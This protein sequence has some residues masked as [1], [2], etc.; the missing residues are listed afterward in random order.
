MTNQLP[1]L[2]VILP[3]F[4]AIFVSILG[5][6][7][8]KASLPLTIAALAGSFYCAIETLKAVAGTAEKLSYRLGG[9]MPPFGIEY[10]IDTLNAMMLVIITAVSLLTAIYSKRGIEKE[11]PDQISSFYTLFLLLVS[12]LLGISITGDVFNLYVLLEI[13][14]LSSYALLAFGKGRAYMSTFQY[15]IM[16]TI[17]ACFYL[18][19]VGY[20][21]LKT[22][23]LNMMHL[24]TILPSLLASKAILVAFIFIMLG[25]WIK[26]ALFPLH[27]WLPNAYSHAPTA[28]SCLIAPL[29]TKVSV[30]VMIRLMFTVF[31]AE[32]VFQTVPWSGV[33]IHIA[34]IAIIA[35]SLFALLQ[36]DL[37]KMLAYIVVAEVGYMVGGAWSNSAFGLAG[38]I[39]HILAD[40]MMTLCLFMAVGC[41]IY[42]TGSSSFDSMK[43]IFKKMPVTMVAFVIGAFSMIGIPPTCGF[44]SKWYLI[45]GALESGNWLFMIALLVSSLINVVL[46][47]RLFEIGFFG[48]VESGEADHRTYKRDEA[49]NSML[50]PLLIA[51]ASCIA[52][53]LYTKEII[54]SVIQ[55]AI[56]GSLL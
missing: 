23:T 18:I 53:G 34:T 21:L 51:S 55:F 4:A 9:W 2:I 35:G 46:F 36:R 26:M 20:L 38:S 54:L 16:G 33:I 22:G 52:I 24:S 29:M 44:F 32:Y 11:M 13:A 30:Y 25:M 6:F 14:A 43:G 39:Y 3:L 27:G 17:G 49:P 50:I 37:K 48:D 41:I 28:V 15:L 10:S 42:K 5:W 19:G 1:I 45:L 47:F 7:N 31:G 56:P 40:A 12:G 8:K